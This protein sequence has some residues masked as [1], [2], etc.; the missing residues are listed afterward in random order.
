MGWDDTVLGTG[1][2]LCCKRLGNQ[3]NK[4]AKIN[5][6]TEKVGVILLLLTNFS[7]KRGFKEFACG[8]MDRSH[9]HDQVL[10][11]EFSGL[12]F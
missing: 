3:A 10:N 5:R 2:V 4:T 1:G 7:F 11:D 9:L 12:W 6:I 8:L